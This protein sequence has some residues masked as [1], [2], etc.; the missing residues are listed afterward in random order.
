MV[1]FLTPDTSETLYTVVN[2]V[3]R[4]A[5]KMKL[6]GYKKMENG[7]FESSDEEES[8]GEDESHSSCDSD[9]DKA[10]KRPRNLEGNIKGPRSVRR[11]NVQRKP[12]GET[13]AAI[14]ILFG[15]R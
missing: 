2:E 12:R 8:S 1:K 3:M 7:T 10:Y 4:L 11:K 5:T 9:D 14:V 13:G 6:K 15:M